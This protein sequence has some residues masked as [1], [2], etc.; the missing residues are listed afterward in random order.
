MKILSSL[1]ILFLAFSLSANAQQAKTLPTATVKTLDGKTVSTATFENDGKPIILSFWASWCR[2]CIKELSAIADLYED[3]Q[4]ETGVKL[5]AISIDDSR[6]VNNVRPLVNARGWDYEFYL[7][8]N[9]DLRRAMGV[10]NVPH[11]FILNGNKEV[12]Y[13]Y[14][15]YTEGSEYELFN[16]IKSLIK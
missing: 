15:N 6:T 10:T 12:M 13:Q 3:W 7:D 16:Q 8:S 14:T 4:D 9:S 2:P 1:G 5:I 11:T